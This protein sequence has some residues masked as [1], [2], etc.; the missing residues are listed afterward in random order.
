MRL[1][2]ATVRSDIAEIEFV[3]VERIDIGRPIS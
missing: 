2:G 1:T 3:Q